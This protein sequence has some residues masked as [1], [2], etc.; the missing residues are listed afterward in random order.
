[1]SQNYQ[2]GFQHCLYLAW[3]DADAGAG[4]TPVPVKLDTRPTGGTGTAPASPAVH[5]NN[6][7]WGEYANV[8]TVNVGGS[9]TS[10]DITTRDEARSGFNTNVIVTTQG[11]MSFDIRYKPRADDGSVQDAYF[12]ALLKAWLLKTEI[13]A[14][15]LDKPIADLGAQGLVGNWT[16]N[17]SN[18]KELQGVVMCTVEMNLSSLP[19]WIRRSVAGAGG[20]LIVS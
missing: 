7:P 13:A 4:V 3:T 1:M 2:F 19:N 14:I 20:F 17:I 10:V 11:Q 6:A 16:V 8:T 5:F 15:D 9:S 12:E 18:K